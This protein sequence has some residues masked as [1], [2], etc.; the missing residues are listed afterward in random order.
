MDITNKNGAE[1]DE[2]EDCH[3]REEDIDP[4][5]IF[6]FPKREARDDSDDEDE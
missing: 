6:E 1:Q 5:M 2:D 3:L 4:T